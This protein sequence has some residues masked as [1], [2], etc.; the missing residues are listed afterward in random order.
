MYDD[1]GSSDY[2][3]YDYNTYE[4][5]NTYDQY[6]DDAEEVEEVAV[7]TAYA[8]SVADWYY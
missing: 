6:G 7:D 3:S 2:N 8:D 1:S 5:S 4:D